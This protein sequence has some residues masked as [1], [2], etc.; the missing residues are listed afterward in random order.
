MALAAARPERIMLVTDAMAAAG[1]PDGEFRL[2][3]R[4]VRVR[5]G[6]A[7][8]VSDDGSPGPIAGSTLTM[9]GAFLVMTAITGDIPTVAALAST[10]AARHFGQVEVGRIEPGCRADLCVVDDQGVLKRVMQA[11]LWLPRPDAG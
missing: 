6:E 4:H 9:A 3:G 2:G 1:M 7:R 10:N 5:Q 8:L 11:G